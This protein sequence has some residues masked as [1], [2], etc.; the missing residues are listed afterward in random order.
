M[1]RRYAHVA[2]RLRMELLL[3]NGGIYV[4]A[5]SLV[6]RDLTPLR[7]QVPRA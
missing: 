2:D 3:L 5:D 4:D 7:E 1:R 6:L